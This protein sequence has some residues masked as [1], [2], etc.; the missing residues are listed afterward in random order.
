MLK[1]AVAIIMSVIL[2]VAC[3]AACS[4]DES[5]EGKVLIKIGSWP[6][7][8]SPEANIQ[9]YET[10]LA[11]MNEAFPNVEIL[12]DTSSFDVK[13]FAIKASSGQLPNLYQPHYTEVEKIVNSGY[14]RDLTD[15]MEKNGY[16]Q[17]LNPALAE[18]LTINGKIWA[19]PKTCSVQGLSCNKELFRQAGLVDEN[20]MPIYPKTYEELARTA[21]T[22][23]EKTGKSGIT[24]CSTNG[25]GGWYF[26]MIAM[27]FGVN[28]VEKKGDK[29]IAAFNTPEFIEALEYIYDLKWKYDVLPDNSFVDRIEQR[30]LFATNQTAMT[31]D[32]PPCD[33]YVTKYGMELDD[34]CFA[35]IP[36][37]KAGR[38]ALIGGMLYMVSPETTDEQ[39]DAIFKWIDISGEGPNLTPE[40]EKTLEET[41]KTTAQEGKA[42]T[43]RNMMD[44]WVNSEIIDK[45]NELRS[46]YN[47]VNDANFEDYFSF[48]DVVIRPEVS[49]CAQQLYSILDGGIQEILTNKKVDI[50]KLAASMCNDF[51]VNHLSKWED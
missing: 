47:N 17:K 7:D 28:F 18:L 51:Q 33:P 30:K 48:E 14:A 16:L 49:P 19:L 35:R 38:V 43:S 4:K 44:I 36:A 39:L 13:S 34:I 8:G 15:Y 21:L 5:T 46:K 29:Y 27:G 26:S 2:C 10:K 31:I 9:Q 41:Y 50:K 45:Q 6:G 32:Y 11:A 22:I 24:I 20:G 12:K 37:G 3:F 1:R 25:Q 23:K 42:V 40:I